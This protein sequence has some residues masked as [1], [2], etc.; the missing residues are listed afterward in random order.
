MTDHPGDERIIVG[1][2]LTGTSAYL[3]HRGFTLLLQVIVILPC[4]TR[5]L[6]QSYACALLQ[7]CLRHTFKPSKT[8]QGTFLLKTPLFVHMFEPEPPIQATY[9]T[10]WQGCVTVKTLGPER[11]WF[12]SSD[13]SFH[14]ALLAWCPFGMARVA[15]RADMFHCR[16]SYSQ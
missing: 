8:D 9:A 2:K 4:K 11:E 3:S 5:A 13:R 6:N 10:Q 7:A 1:S 14:V 16:D 15:C 12:R